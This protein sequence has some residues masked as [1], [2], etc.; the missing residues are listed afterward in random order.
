MWLAMLRGSGLTALLPETHD[1]SRQ[2]DYV[3]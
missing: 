1:I 3:A 2:Q